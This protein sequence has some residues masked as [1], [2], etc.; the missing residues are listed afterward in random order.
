MLTGVLLYFLGLLVTED[1]RTSGTK[2][3]HKQVLTVLVL[4]P[5]DV[6]VAVTKLITPNYRNGCFEP[7]L[8]QC[9]YV[10]QYRHWF[11]LS[12]A[13]VVIVSQ[14]RQRV[15]EIPFLGRPWDFAQTSAHV[16]VRFFR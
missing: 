7:S 1:D 12:S 9:Y 16:L 11:F 5:I 14:L 2:R 13:G 10:F 8:Y 15:D 6:V 4:M 3:Q